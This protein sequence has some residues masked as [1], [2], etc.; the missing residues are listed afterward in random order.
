MGMGDTPKSHGGRRPGAGR[1]PTRRG[2]VLRAL[3][4]LT[5]DDGVTYA[6]P[7]HVVALAGF[8]KDNVARVLRGLVED[9]TYVELVE[10]ARL[11]A[12]AADVGSVLLNSG[13]NPDRSL[14]GASVPPRSRSVRR[15]KREKGEP[16]GFAP[17]FKFWLPRRYL[18]DLSRAW[19]RRE[20]PSPPE[21]ARLFARLCWSA[22]LSA[23]LARFSEVT[24]RDVE[25][26]DAAH[27]R[28]LRAFTARLAEGEVG[29]AGLLDR[30]VYCLG[31]CHRRLDRAWGRDHEWDG[32]EAGAWD[33]AQAIARYLELE[34]A[35][36]S[37]PPP[38]SLLPAEEERR[39]R[40]AGHVRI[41]SEEEVKKP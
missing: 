3:R 31:D 33:E 21:R 38:V 11:Y 22:R 36:S 17:E 6:H 20:P 26:T 8:Q 34:R 41:V 16:V 27:R 7:E 25:L 30:A 28:A 9:G 35:E 15:T 14:I 19:W 5:D 1:R 39:S 12:C 18:R 13:A 29:E 10:G 24:G 32:S 2:A 40:A 37:A 4:A 23:L